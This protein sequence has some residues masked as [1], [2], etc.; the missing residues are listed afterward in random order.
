[1]ER[2]ERLYRRGSYVDPAYRRAL[3]ERV[4]PLLRRHGLTGSAATLRGAAAASPPP[5]PPGGEQLS[6]L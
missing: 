6:L 1:V 4:G 5:P 2:Y 3:G